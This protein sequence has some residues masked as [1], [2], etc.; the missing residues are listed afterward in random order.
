[1]VAGDISGAGGPRVPRARR[2]RQRRRTPEGARAARLHLRGRRD[3]RRDAGRGG[4]CEPRRAA[5]AQG[6][7]RARWRPSSSSRRAH[8]TTVRALGGDPMAH[9]ELVGRAPE[10]AALRAF[11]AA[12]AKGRGGA[13]RLVGEAGT[14]KSRL[15]AE[16]GACPER[17]GL[18]L[19]AARGAP[20]PAL[21]DPSALRALASERPL[22]LVLDDLDAAGDVG[23]RRARRFAR[24]HRERGDRLRARPPARPRGTRTRAR[25]A[26]WIAPGAAR[27]CASSRS[28]RS[29]A[30]RLVASVPRWPARHGD[31]VEADRRARERGARASASRPRSC[32]PRS[33]PSRRGPGRDGDA[34]RRRATILFADITG[35]T[36]MTERLGA[37]RAY[38]IVAD[39]LRAARRGGAQARRHRRQVSRRLRD[40]ALRRARGDRGCAARGRQRRDRDAPPRARVQPRARPASSRSTCTTAIHTGLGIAGDIS[41]PMIRE[42]AVMGEPV[43]VADQLTDLAAAG[44][45][46]RRRGDLA[47]DARR[48]SLSGAA[49]RSRLGGTRAARSRLRAALTRRSSS[50]GARIGEP[51]GRSSR[52][53][54]AAT[55]S[56]ARCASAVG[57]STAA[58]ADDREPDRRGGPRKVA[59][60]RRAR[61]ARRRA[62]S[63]GSRAARSR[64]ASSLSFH[65]FADLVPLLGRDHRRRRRGRVRARSCDAAV[66]R[67]CR[68]SE[69]RSSFPSS[70]R[71]GHAAR[72]EHERAPRRDAG[73]RARADAA[74][75][76]LTRV[77][78][79]PSEQQP[80]VLVIDDLH[81][82]D[83]SSIELLEALAAARRGAAASS[84]CTSSRPDFGEHLGA[85]ARRSCASSTP[86]GSREIELEPL[87]AARPCAQPHQQ[88]VPRTATSRTRR[89]AHDRDEGA[90]QSVL[91]RGGGAL[92]GRPGRGR[93]RDGQ[94]PRHGEASTTS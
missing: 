91:R 42:F 1:M 72:A 67:C 36:A 27:R 22:L 73:R 70:R 8:A 60:R 7:V 92:A 26:A 17:E 48:A 50:T 31:G 35:F 11:A 55:R 63:S 75:R 39:C 93:V 62:T 49:S 10:L 77:P 43:S 30:R 15:L 88:P 2:C 28:T 21:L 65:P 33:A 5:A 76:G 94:L 69:R 61:R 68:A 85:R 34:E 44:S 14:G 58:A 57:A 45:D 80:L 13:L 54:S 47:L 74:A 90:R 78:A 66:A 71:H 19:R 32:R 82:A 18:T 51:S 64:P 41:G 23:A 9:S 84:S 37:E 59:A 56:C 89:G 20:D 81:W 52:R 53:W 83:L 79:E 86:S 3:R 40:G 29:A 24:A 38:P 12:L 25:H 4:V 87:D 46:L 6:E 16:L